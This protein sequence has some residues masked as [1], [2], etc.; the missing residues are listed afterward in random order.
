MRKKKPMQPPPTRSFNRPLKQIT[1]PGPWQDDMRRYPEPQYVWQ[2]AGLWCELLRTSWWTWNGY[3]YYRA[4]DDEA[5]NCDALI[6]HG[7]ITGGDVGSVGFDTGDCDPSYDPEKG[8]YWTYEETRA[9]TESLARQ[10]AAQL[11]Q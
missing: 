2:H 9:E 10:I 1:A 6:V 7:G 4:E 8:H 11:N 3:V 5:L